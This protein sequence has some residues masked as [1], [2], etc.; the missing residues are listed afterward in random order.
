MENIKD[1]RS[2]TDRTNPEK[3]EGE[4]A[5]ASNSFLWAAF[6]SLA[7]SLALTLL[8]RNPALAVG[9]GVPAFLIFGI[10]KMS[11]QAGHSE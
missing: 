5:T 1:L 7:A 2:K 10:Y 9:I 4:D 8:K 6:G 11:R 3:H